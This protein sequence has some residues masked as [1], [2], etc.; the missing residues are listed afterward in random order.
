MK[1]KVDVSGEDVVIFRIEGMAREM[2]ETI[3]RAMSE[4]FIEGTNGLKNY[5]ARVQHG[6]GNPYQWQTEKQRKAYFATNG[7]G[8]GI[9]STRTDTLKNAW[10]YVETS[11]AWDRVYLLNS[12]GYA[13]Y[14]QGANIQRGHVADKWIKAFETVKANISGA[15]KAGQEAVN[16]LVARKRP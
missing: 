11:S 4:Y 1:V 6:E 8:G 12:S 13:K 10:D 15:I 7:F 2:N 3:M 9:P 16:K 14:V 5:P